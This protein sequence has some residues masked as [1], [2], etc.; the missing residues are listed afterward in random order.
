M[1]QNPRPTYNKLSGKHEYSE[2]PQLDIGNDHVQ[3]NIPLALNLMSKTECFLR[4]GKRPK[5][6]LSPLFF[7]IILEIL[8][9][10]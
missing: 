8:A 9:I 6:P 5:C 7:S 4:S 2:L 1:C 10:A 3:K